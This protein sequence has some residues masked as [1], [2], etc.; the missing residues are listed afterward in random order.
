MSENGPNGGDELNVLKPGKNYG[1]PLVSL[2]R[3]YPGP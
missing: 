1:W 2:G 3:Q